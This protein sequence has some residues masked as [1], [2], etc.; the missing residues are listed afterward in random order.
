MKTDEKVLEDGKV[1]CICCGRSN[2]TLI[3]REGKRVCRA[4]YKVAL[5]I[6]AM[7]TGKKS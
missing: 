5:R 4:C 3:V 2:V 1:A 6:R 7:D